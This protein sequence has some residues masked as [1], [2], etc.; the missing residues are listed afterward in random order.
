MHGYIAY[1]AQAAYVAAAFLPGENLL[2]TIAKNYCSLFWSP[3]P[4]TAVP[5]G[6]GHVPGK[7]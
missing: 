1:Q 2:G 7:T 3:Y 4:G 5:P 6:L